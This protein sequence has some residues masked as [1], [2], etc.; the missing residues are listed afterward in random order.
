MKNSTILKDEL[1]I[2][3]ADRSAVITELR[4]VS[5][6]LK[7]K[8]I[9]SSEAET[10]LRSIEDRILNESARLDEVSK[11]TILTKSELTNLLIELKHLQNNYEVSRVK[12][13][14]EV[15]LHLGRIKEVKE[16][17]Q[18]VIKELDELR[19]LYDKNSEIFA[20]HVSEYQTKLRLVEKDLKEKEIQK[21]KVS[22]EVEKLLAEEKKLIKE[23]LRREDNIRKREY[24][25]EAKEV[26]SQKKEED[27]ITMSKDIVIVY[28]RLKELYAK[29]DP[30]IDLD[31][32]ILQAT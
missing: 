16:K 2:L 5:Q 20:V 25:V 23:R 22:A 14:Q 7:E 13:A 29:V 18:E 27:L 12:N 30:T 32:L 3:T 26:S 19:R 6:E 11:K 1:N 15:K 17:E 10:H 24:A 4:R 21:V 28:G 9:L 31:K 8:H